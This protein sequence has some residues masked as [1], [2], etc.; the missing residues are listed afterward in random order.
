MKNLIYLLLFMLLTNNVIAQFSI[1][2]KEDVEKI[3]ERTLVVEILEPDEQTQKR[4]EKE[5]KND[6]AIYLKEIEK[7]NALIKET[8]PKYWKLNNN[9]LFK[10]KAE[11]EIIMKTEDS[12]YLIFIAGRRLEASYGIVQSGQDKRAVELKESFTYFLYLPEYP[13]GWNKRKYVDNVNSFDNNGIDKKKYLMKLSQPTFSN[14]EN[15]IKLI[16]DIFEQTIKTAKEKGKEKDIW[17][18]VFFIPKMTYNPQIKTDTLLI[19]KEN[20][21]FDE[22]FLQKLTN[23]YKIVPIDEIEKIRKEQKVGYVYFTILWDDAHKAFY[24]YFINSNNNSIYSR[25]KYASSTLDNFF[26]VF[27]IGAVYGRAE[28]K[29]EDVTHQ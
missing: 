20:V 29:A 18:N 4:I 12:K 21:Q 9:I 11:V 3:I 19:P 28:E 2:L 14:N 10:T 7:Y 17:R 1:P 8:I 24:T 13:D 27:T 25:A 26:I 23:P 15:D 22:M 5:N 16:C 6:V